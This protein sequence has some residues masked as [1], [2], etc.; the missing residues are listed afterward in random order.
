[1]CTHS[2]VSVLSESLWPHWLQPTKLLCP[3]DSPSKDI[4]V[5]CHALLQGIFLTQGSNLHLLWLQHSRRILYRWASR[6]AHW[7]HNPRGKKYPFLYTPSFPGG[8]GVKNPP[9]NAGDAGDVSSIPGLERYPREGNGNPLQYSWTEEK[10]HGQKSLKSYSP[11]GRKIRHDWAT[12]HTRFQGG[13]GL[14]QIYLVLR[15]LVSIHHCWNPVLEA[16]THGVK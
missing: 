6:E 10:F 13:K 16:G 3:W 11:W 9:A 8:S 15:E 14:I 12:E 1:M 5:G 7:N 2:V 4:G